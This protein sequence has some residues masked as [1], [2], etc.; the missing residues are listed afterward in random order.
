[1][2]AGVI[3]A[4]EANKLAIPNRERNVLRV[5]CPNSLR[6]QLSGLRESCLDRTREAPRKQTK[7]GLELRQDIIR[8]RGAEN[9]SGLVSFR[10]AAQRR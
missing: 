6:A 3:R 5:D 8:P 4:A 2:N 10:N 9:E 1:M 7:D